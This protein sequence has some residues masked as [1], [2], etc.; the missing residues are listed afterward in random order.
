LNADGSFVYSPNADFS[1]SD[2]FT[3]CAD[4][5][6]AISN[7]AT[8]T[9]TVNAV[10]DV[11]IATADNFSAAEDTILFV[12][13]A[14]VLA[15]DSDTD[16]DSIAAVLV[17]SPT[18]GTVTLNSDGS[19]AY[20]P[21]ANFTGIDTFTYQANDGTANSNVVTV[22]ITVNPID[23]APVA[24]GDSYSVNEDGSLSVT[25]AGVLANDSDIE[26]FPL[27]ATLVTGP[28]NGTLTLNS[29]GSYSYTP[30][31]NFSGLDSF[32][33]RASDGSRTSNVATVTIA[34]NPVN[35]A[36]VVASDSFS[37]AEDS[38]LSIAAAGVLANDGDADG[39]AITAVLVSG[40]SNGTLNLDPD[41]SFTY[42]PDTDFN[43][44]DSFRYRARDGSL[45]SNVTTVAITVSAMNDA[46]AAEADD[47][48][49]EENATLIVPADGVMRNDS[50]PD[51]DSIS[52]L[53]VTGPANGTLTVNANGSFLYQPATGFKGTDSFSYRATDGS[54]SSGVVTV[55][56]TVQSQV[57]PVVMNPPVE[58]DPPPTIDPPPTEPPVSETP[59][60]EPPSSGTPTPGKSTTPSSDRNGRSLIPLREDSSLNAAVHHGL[61]IVPDVNLA[62]FGTQAERVFRASSNSARDRDII[63]VA[64]ELPEMFSSMINIDMLADD[65]DALKK[66]LRVNSTA[67]EIVIG[68]A[69]VSAVG[70]SI[71]YVFWIV[72]GGYLLT[73][74]LT[75]MPAWRFVDP[76]PVLEY[77]GA[78]AE[79]NDKRDRETLASMLDEKQ[80]ESTA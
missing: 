25:A 3:Y 14:G 50:D 35:D 28:A 72:R 12:P 8:V 29:N 1:G 36:P 58:P 63:T 59:P 9:I 77:L 75:S 21:N 15:N 30:F 70:I 38:V 44:T 4:D 24:V 47:Y 78:D 51:G 66:L 40:P 73:S 65:L 10:N 37:V 32:Q 17:S 20:T 11:P 7:V 76:L 45:N 13:A 43:G 27:T 61:T 23:D 53:V 39:N 56:L 16:G 79:S 52:V 62:E 67:E 22:T 19:F 26:G 64:A 49:V 42:L 2:S 46:P 33:Y 60:G 55:L 18:N 74:L 34:V 57:P 80:T 41:G 6:T 68:S 54:L 71:G 5:G 31:A 48:T 69:L